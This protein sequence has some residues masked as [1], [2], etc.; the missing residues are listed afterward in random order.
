MRKSDR[1][2]DDVSSIWRAADWVSV[3]VLGVVGFLP[4]DFINRYHAIGSAP[5]YL[6]NFIAINDRCLPT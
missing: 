6:F 2:L 1:E 4:F 3:L 5:R